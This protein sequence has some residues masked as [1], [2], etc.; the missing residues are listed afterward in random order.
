MGSIRRIQTRSSPGLS[1]SRAPGI[2]ILPPLSGVA[3]VRLV[4]NALVPDF[5]NLVAPA[6]LLAA[7]F[8]GCGQKAEQEAGPVVEE[9][10]VVV[11]VEAEEPVLNVYNWS[12]YIA[13][14]TI[15][16]FEERTGITVNYDVFDS[17]EVVEAKLLAGNTGY[18]IVV[19]SAS[20]LERQIKA[21]VFQKLDREKL[22]NWSNLDEDIMARV[23]DTPPDP[24]DEDCVACHQV[25]AV[26]LQRRRTWC[27]TGGGHRPDD[28]LHLPEREDLSVL[29][30]GV[31]IGRT[32]RVAFGDVVPR[33]G[34]RCQLPGQGDV[35]GVQ[36]RVDDMRDLHPLF[37]GDLQLA[38]DLVEER[39]Y[40]GQSVL[41][42]A[43]GGIGQRAGLP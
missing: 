20:F 43:L 13:E 10:I 27:V 21:G 30:G 4:V 26:D 17:N 6:P 16:N 41:V 32:F 3:S 9:E 7:L 29:E 1:K 40:L 35:V 14:D 8:V 38:R 28:H 5:I 31:L 24:G 36:M 22:S 42:T 37:A 25:A 23:P 34:V 18:D 11:E 15:A 12:D 19:P 33:V 2:A 39:A